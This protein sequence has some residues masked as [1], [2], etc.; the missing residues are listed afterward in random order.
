MIAKK[1]A[2]SSHT[3]KPR[4][5]RTCLKHFLDPNKPLGVHY[6]AIIGLQAIGGAETVRVLL[7]PNLKP[8]EAI[9]K[10]EITDNGPK[11][12][13]A[14]LVLSA[15]M[16]SLQSLVKDRASMANGNAGDGA[17]ELRAKVIDKVGELVGNKIF[18][19]GRIPVAQA[20]VED[21]LQLTGV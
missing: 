15:I 17:E 21:Q 6:G 8:Y 2:K 7:I 14:E 20:V 12:S 3:L 1:Y 10:D 18:E 9:I 4:L 13:E 11:K 5:A 16:A 19:L